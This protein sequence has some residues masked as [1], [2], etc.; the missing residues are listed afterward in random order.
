[1]RLLF[2]K[3][4]T[5]VEIWYFL[6]DLTKYCTYLETKFSVK[7]TFS[8]CRLENNV[9]IYVFSMEI[10]GETTIRVIFYKL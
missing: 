5:N 9:S 2:Y 1:M 10:S 8:K 7:M 6:F 3:Q 4:D